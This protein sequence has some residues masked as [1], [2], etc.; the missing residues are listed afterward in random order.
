MKYFGRVFFEIAGVC[1]AKCPYCITGNKNAPPGK[2]IS[3]GMFSDILG[4]LFAEKVIDQN[5]R[6]YLFNKGEPF[7]HPNLSGIIDILHNYNLKYEISTN[8]SIVP[9]I[10]KKLVSGLQLLTFSMPGFSQ[11]SYDKIHGFDFEEIKTN[12]TE[13]V[14]QLKQHGYENFININYHLYQFSLLE[15][16]D[17]EFFARKLGISLEPMF[18]FINDWWIFNDWLNDNLSQDTQKKMMEELLFFSEYKRLLK[19]APEG[20]SCDQFNVLV[21]DEEGNMATCCGLP[22]E[23]E[24]YHCG[25]VLNDDIDQTLRN[26]F[27]KPVCDYCHKEGITYALNEGCVH[28]ADIFAINNDVK[29]VAIFGAGSGGK[30]ALELSSRCGWV[31]AYFVDSNANIG[32]REFLNGYDVKTPASLLERDFELI[33]VATGDGK[34]SVFEQLNNMGFSYQR[35]YIH[36]LDTVIVDNCEI[37][38]KTGKPKS[39]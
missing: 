16:K 11:N 32:R 39:K 23:H 13:I 3:A 4:K 25:N 31:V 1:N 19:S 38:V 24:D 33:I 30:I 18:A 34:K 7:L 26:K 5:T 17:C 28:R 6:I 22:K 9:H 14:R 20:Y 37:S 15:I 2:I 12:M 36:F 21:I 27:N 35:D 29:R 8:G 10:D